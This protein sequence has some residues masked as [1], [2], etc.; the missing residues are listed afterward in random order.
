MALN[1]LPVKGRRIG[2]L[3]HVGLS[4]PPV[5]QVQELGLHVDE[6]RVKLFGR[7]EQI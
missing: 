7:E 3:K 5:N 4:G 6:V 1:A 2:M